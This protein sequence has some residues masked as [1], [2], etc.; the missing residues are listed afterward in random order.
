MGAAR[1][2]SR[3]SRRVSRKRRTTRRVSR[4]RRVVRKRRVSRKKRVVKRKKAR[5]PVKKETG[6]M[7]SVWEGKAKKTKTG[8]TKRSLMMKDGKVVAK[9]SVIGTRLQVFRGKKERTSG[10]L[11]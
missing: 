6:S 5:K 7:K 3:K 4:K 2:A 10:G 8:L 9:T 11:T 1:R